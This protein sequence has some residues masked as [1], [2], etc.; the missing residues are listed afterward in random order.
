M[1]TMHKEQAAI[2]SLLLASHI[3]DHED[4]D[5]TLFRKAYLLVSCLAYSSSLKMKSVH[6]SE[7]AACRLTFAGYFRALLF[8]PADGRST[9]FR[10]VYLLCEPCWLL[11]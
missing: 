8:A 4:G 6:S 11:V 3:F 9:F 5:I 7:T 1:L 10:N 2:V